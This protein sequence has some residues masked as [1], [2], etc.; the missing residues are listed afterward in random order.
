MHGDAPGSGLLHATTGL[1]ALVGGVV[2]PPVLN[3]AD[4]DVPSTGHV[5][6]ADPCLQSAQAQ[7]Q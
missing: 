3:A 5:R 4:E 1:K 7:L 6:E 2:G